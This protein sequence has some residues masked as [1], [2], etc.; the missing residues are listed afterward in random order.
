MMFHSGSDVLLFGCLLAF[1]F[2]RRPDW[3]RRLI[4]SSWAATALILFTLFVIPFAEFFLPFPLFHIFWVA[5]DTTVES[6]LITLIVANVL[7]QPT[8]WYARV[9]RTRGLVSLGLIS[10]SAYLWQQLFCLPFNTT[11][12]GWFPINLLCALGAGWLSHR[13]I[14][15]PFL[16]AKNKRYSHAPSL[17]Q[18]IQLP[19]S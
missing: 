11:F 18:E 7:L 15:R 5:A 10:Y 14:E 2:I 17:R 9:L 4:L 3:A 12:T 13:L 8:A 1:C 6:V 16:R 19:E